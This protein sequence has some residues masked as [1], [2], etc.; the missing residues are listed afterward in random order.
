[1]LRGWEGN[2]GCGVVMTA[3]C[4]VYG[5]F[6]HRLLLCSISVTF[7]GRFSTDNWRQKHVST[8]TSETLE[9]PPT[10]CTASEYNQFW[11][12]PSFWPHLGP[13][14][15]SWRY[16][17]RFKSYHKDKHTNQRTLVSENLTSRYAI[18]VQ[19]VNILL[20]LLLQV[21]LGVSWE[22]NPPQKPFSTSLPITQSINYSIDQSL[23]RSLNQSITQ[24]IDQSINH[25]ISQSVSHSLTH[26]LTQSLTHS[27]TH[28]LT[29]S[30][31]Q[32]INS[33]TQSSIHTTQSLTHPINQSIN[34]SLN[35]L[36]NQSIT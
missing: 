29:Q 25:L 2:C 30:I 34:Q 1:M 31:D 24:S 21:L 22:I 11:M 13:T 7:R 28:S 16:L 14:Q 19:V 23:N 5:T 8:R 33:L 20:L 26:S 12:H 6:T 35:Q 3:N 4:W 17:I 32:S 27:L 9:S 36:I 10:R 15:L 18:A